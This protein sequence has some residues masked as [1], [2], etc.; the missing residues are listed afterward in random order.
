[1]MTLLDVQHITKRFGGLTAVN[2]VSFHVD[3]GEVVSII[4]PN[5][6]GKTT[7]FNILT[8]V[9]EI[10]E[11]KI[12]FEGKE[13]QN[14]APQAIVKAGISRTFQNIRLFMNMR[15]LE[16][17]LVGTHINTEYGFID[18]LFRT[19]KW[20]RIEAEKTKR[21]IQILK[22]IGLEH[23]MHDYAKNLPYGEQRKLEIARAIATG[24][25]L[26]LLDEPPTVIRAEFIIY[27]VKRVKSR[28]ICDTL[29][30]LLRIRIRRQVHFATFAL[31]K[32]QDHFFAGLA[33]FFR[34]HFLKSRIEPPKPFRTILN[35]MIQDLSHLFQR[36]CSVRHVN[37]PPISFLTLLVTTQVSLADLIIVFELLSIS[38]Q[39]NRAGFHDIGTVCN[40]KRHVCVLFDQ[41]NRCALLIDGLD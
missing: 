28:P 35:R 29:N 1:M 34:I 11:G 27:H 13:I 23:R 16:N 7:V 10:E 32:L 6:A 26:L 39:C 8:G 22:S 19:P 21:A 40:G 31:P 17:V 24:A 12:F 5:G 2:N 33:S 41:Q 15:V 18:A 37:T 38:A 14:Q 9:Y 36:I 20:R 3:K 25:K 30:K 4:G